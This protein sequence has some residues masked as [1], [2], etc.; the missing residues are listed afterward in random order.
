MKRKTIL[1][2][3]I[4][5]VVIIIGLVYFVSREYNRKHKDVANVTAAF[6]LSTDEVIAAFSKDEKNANAKYLDKVMSV[7]GT[8]KSLDK[9][10]RGFYTVILGEPNSMSS[11]RA[12]MDSSHNDEAMNL[13]VGKKIS[14]KGICTGFNADEL[15]GSD[16]ILNRCTIQQ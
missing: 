13:P 8:V 11:V 16:V 1:Y 2:S 7:N 3:F 9:D 15:L 6:T 10:D 12:V 5:I 14:I 4:T